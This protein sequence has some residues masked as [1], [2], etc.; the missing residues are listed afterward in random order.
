[1]ETLQIWKK[2]V[3][4][5]ILLTHSVFVWQNM[6]IFL[7]NMLFILMCNEFISKLIKF[8]KFLSFNFKF[9]KYQQ[10][11]PPINKSC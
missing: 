6:V 4:N 2:H 11:Q 10:I 9:S 7:K 8:K 5:A 3:N 1:M